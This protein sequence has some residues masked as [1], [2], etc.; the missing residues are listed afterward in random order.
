[1]SDVSRVARYAMRVPLEFRVINQPEWVEAYTVNLSASG[2]LLE[3]SHELR[4]G[5]VLWLRSKEEDGESAEIAATCRV[6]RIERGGDNHSIRLGVRFL[7]YE[8]ESRDTG[9]SVN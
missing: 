6:V 7:G 5:D 1:V 9:V 2:A 3:C 4:P 8:F